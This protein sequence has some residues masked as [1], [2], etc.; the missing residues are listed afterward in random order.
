MGRSTFLVAFFH[1][2]CDASALVCR[3]INAMR[4]NKNHT[5]LARIRQ[6]IPSSSR[7]FMMT[8]TSNII[9]DLDGSCTEA[10]KKAC[11]FC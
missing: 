6:H 7:D 11:M 10:N 1:F 4:L 8:S 9:N 2:K 3:Q 5:T